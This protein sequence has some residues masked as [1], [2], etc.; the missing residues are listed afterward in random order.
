MITNKVGSHTP[1][2][3]PSL[4]APTSPPSSI[5][6]LPKDLVHL[7]K[8]YLPQES[9]HF[10]SETCKQIRS[11]ANLTLSLKG[12]SHEGKSVLA[13]LSRTSSL[14]ETIDCSYEDPTLTSCI[15]QLLSK[16]PF[17]QLKSLNLSASNISSKELKAILEKCPNIESLNLNVCKRVGQEDFPGLAPLL[18]NLHTLSLNDCYIDTPGLCAIA[19]HC[20]SLKHLSLANCHHIT[21]E[22][23]S[24]LANTKSSLLSLD[25]EGNLT[26]TGSVLVQIIKKHGQTLQTL[27]LEGCPSIDQ[28]CYSSI[29]QH[30]LSLI[31]LNLARSKISGDDLKAI[32]EKCPNIESL[33]LNVCKRVGQEDFPGL[34]PLLSNLHTLSL[35]DCYIDT[36]GLCAIAEHCTSLK[37]L[38]L[39]NCHHIT[40]EGFSA[41]ANTK[42]SLLS[43]DLEGSPTLT[44]SVL[45][46]ITKKHGQTLENLTL[47]SCRLVDQASFSSISEDCPNLISLN[48]SFNAT[49][50]TEVIQSIASNCPKIEDLDLSDCAEVDD[51]T[52]KVLATNSKNLQ[53]LALDSSSITDQALFSL[54]DNASRLHTVELYSCEEITNSGVLYLAQHCP[55]Q[56]IDLTYCTELSQQDINQVIAHS[57]RLREIML[58]NGQKL[59]YEEIALRRAALSLVEIAQ[60]SMQKL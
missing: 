30:C 57:S 28:R 34:A 36:P 13:V 48:L 19:E 39:A 40:E 33:N 42:S 45:V 25:L 7:V 17:P 43:L 37:H 38:S 59:R 53:R 12:K 4:P 26:L 44:G 46:Q 21:E 20:T 31:N 18:S 49:I 24:A 23:F 41:L 27:N 9:R 52:I 8:Q 60:S 6:S 50:D 54:G 14:I 22:G 1:Q 35:N 16:T 10:L 29:G 32:L 51:N 58:L 3:T 15:L 56:K 11:C 2:A 47:S 5:Y 55:L